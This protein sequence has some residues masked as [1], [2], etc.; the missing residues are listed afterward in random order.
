MSHQTLSSHMATASND[1]LPAINQ[2][3]AQGPAQ[4]TP[5][6]FQSD[7]RPALVTTDNI[8]APSIVE[9]VPQQ[10][11]VDMDMNIDLQQTPHDKDAQQDFIHSLADKVKDMER[12]M[13][14]L[15]DLY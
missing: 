2:S 10:Q 5:I 9:M 3:P 14:K 6:I 4:D 1:L 13:F 7:Q 11:Q 15:A 8:A 12:L